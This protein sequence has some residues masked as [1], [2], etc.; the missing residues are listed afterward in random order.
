MLFS[1]PVEVTRR[2]AKQQKEQQYQSHIPADIALQMAVSTNC[3]GPER[4]SSGSSSPPTFVL[5]VISFDSPS[6]T[7]ATVTGPNCEPF[8]QEATDTP[9]AMNID[10]PANAPQQNETNPS[11]TAAVS[12]TSLSYGVFKIPQ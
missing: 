4:T 10:T 11:A 7:C 2:A 3:Q 9:T 12:V 5:Q 6:V 1:L 8:K